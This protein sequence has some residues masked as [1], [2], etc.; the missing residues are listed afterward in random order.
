MGT[1]EIQGALWDHA[2]QDWSLLQEPMHRPLWEDMLA[3]A[4]VSPG[5]HILD[6]GCGGGGA[7]VLSDERGAQ[8][9]GIDASEGLIAL[10]SE[11]VPEGDF[12]VG[13]IESL[14]FEDYAFDAVI[15]ANSIQ[16]AG[17]RVATFCEFARVCRPSG[18]IVAGLFRPPDKVEFRI[19]FGAVRDVLPEPPPGGGPFELSMPGKLE[20]LFEEAGLEVLK[21]GEVDCPFYY[22]DFETFWRANSA[23]GPLQGVIQNIGEEKIKSTLLR[24]VEPYSQ[25]GSGIIIQPNVF[26]YVVATL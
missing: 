22:P 3:E 13:D 21:S 14:P 26:K 25:D 24:A 2:P 8:V 15:A 4:L 9:S 17:D 1:A 18:R 7:S 6:A 20:S 19:F 10:A 12:R 5:T 16:Y 11:R 23:A